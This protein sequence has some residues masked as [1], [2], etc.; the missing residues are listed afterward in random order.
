MYGSS[1]CVKFILYWVLVVFL[2]LSWFSLVIYH[3]KFC[4]VAEKLSSC[5][6]FCVSVS[7]IIPNH[8]YLNICM[9]VPNFS[10][11]LIWHFHVYIYT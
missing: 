7:N 2:E 8:S 6:H 1:E 3:E 10:K 5:L 9:T 11:F 4:F